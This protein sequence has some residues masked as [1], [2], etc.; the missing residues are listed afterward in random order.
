MKKGNIGAHVA[1][2]DKGKETRN[3]LHARERR[4]KELPVRGDEG[5]RSHGLS[6]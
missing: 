3:G 1:C 2:D 6:A 4:I 5:N